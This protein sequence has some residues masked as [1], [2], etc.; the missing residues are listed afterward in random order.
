MVRVTLKIIL[1]KLFLLQ[2]SF[3]LTEAVFYS[4]NDILRLMEKEY[5]FD[6]IIFLKAFEDEEIYHEVIV[7]QIV[8]NRLDLNIMPI[9]NRTSSH[10]LTVVY[11][12]EN[13]YQQ[14]INLTEQ[15]LWKRHWNHILIVWREKE[16]D[17][18]LMEVVFK[19][20]LQKGM[21]N[22]LIWFDQMLYSYK[23]YPHVEVL[24][25][26]SFFSYGKERHLSDFQGYNFYTPFITYP[27]RCF[28][29]TDIHGR[30]VRSGTFFK[31]NELFAQ[32]YNGNLLI[33]YEYN[34]WE[35]NITQESAVAFL[36][37][38]KFD[39]GS[40]L[41]I[42]DEFYAP[43]DVLWLQKRYL[44]V[45][46]SKEIPQHFYIFKTFSGKTWLVVLLIFMCVFGF[47]YS[48]N[49]RHDKRFNRK[50][51]KSSLLQTL[52]VVSYL[53]Y[54]GLLKI[55]N[56]FNVLYIL[57]NLLAGFMLVNF[58]NCS[59][60]SLLVTKLYNPSLHT[61]EDIGKTQLYIYEYSVDAAMYKDFDLPPIILKRLRS[62]N[63][64]YMKYHRKHL[65]VDLHIYSCHEDVA[66]YYLLQQKYL[67]K[68]KAK[69]LEEA[70]YTNTFHV[71][72]RHRAPFYDHFNRYLLYIK[73]S[74][75]V[76]KIIADS[77]W[78][79]I[80]MGDIVFFDNV[81]ET[82]PLTLEHL[83]FAF[84]V[85]VAGLMMAMITFLYEIGIVK[86]LKRRCVLV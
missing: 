30:L 34:I 53:P 1:I 3:Y 24:K 69:L 41:L 35:S 43:S 40:T 38:V 15:I 28:S 17:L 27:P 51:S 21:I 18:L 68:P 61:L 55:N 64:E 71:T 52:A 37:R 75:I 57:L 39:F 47:I 14:L 7:P 26:H 50:C 72:L 22:V 23:P 59:L 5:Q 77:E 70:I 25:L 11:M 42:R 36:S 6:T 12:S 85:L 33:S 20:L 29:F 84:C 58:F 4:K 79:G 65:D 31:I 73:E 13:D 54:S 60:S 80:R 82:K 45:P 56:P 78:D 9:F 19:E 67:N 10:C 48:V 86:R 49:K 32:H 83:Y 76:H 62:D 63:N 2:Q 44:I 46:I 81:E 66:K 16:F 8:I 74:G